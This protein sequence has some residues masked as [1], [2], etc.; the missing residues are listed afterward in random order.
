MND[1]NLNSHFHPVRIAARDAFR[2]LEHAVDR[3]D[4]G[5]HSALQIIDH[6]GMSDEDKLLLIEQQLREARDKAKGS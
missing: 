5:V 4:T 6:P 1:R 3:L 2:A